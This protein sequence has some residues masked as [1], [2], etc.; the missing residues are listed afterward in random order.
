MVK[1]A[2]LGF[3]FVG[4]ISML[5]MSFHYFQA[6]DSGILGNKEVASENWYILSFRIHILF[7][8]IAIATGPVQFIKRVRTGYAKVH[9]RMGFIY[10]TSVVFSSLSGLVISRFAM[11]GMITATGFGTLSVLWFFI[12]SKSVLTLVKGDFSGHKK[13]SFFGYSLTFSAITQ[14]ILLLVPLL[15]DVPFLPIYRLSAWLPWLV[16]LY[17]ANA[18]LITS[19]KRNFGFPNNTR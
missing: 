10:F 16:N 19:T 1:K 3:L 15:T 11:G 12:T 8:L 7:G 2:F 6:E 9:K 5:V 18:L 13:W 4:A 14:R 17:I